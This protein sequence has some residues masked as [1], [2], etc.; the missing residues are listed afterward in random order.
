MSSINSVSTPA[1]LNWGADPMLKP[2]WEGFFCWK[3]AS[4]EYPRRGYCFLCT[5]L[6]FIL[7]SVFSF[8]FRKII[9][10][11]TSILYMFF[12]CFWCFCQK[13]RFFAFHRCHRTIPTC[14]T[15]G[16]HGIPVWMLSCSI[17]KCSTFER[18]V[19]RLNALNPTHCIFWQLE[20]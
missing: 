9:L 2:Q 1:G 12:P 13:Y 11:Y 15:K 5:I 7:F 14:W 18:D 6:L 8:V 20:I 3:N 19:Q 17:L 16:C 10:N 4:I